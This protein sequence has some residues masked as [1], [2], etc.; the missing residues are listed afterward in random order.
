MADK[1]KGDD[2]AQDV[3]DGFLKAMEH[4]LVQE[5]GLGVG[6]DRFM[7]L[8]CNEQSIRECIAFPILREIK[9]DKKE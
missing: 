9:N 7:M 3:D 1:A 2:E 4:G 6:I 8:L 5:S